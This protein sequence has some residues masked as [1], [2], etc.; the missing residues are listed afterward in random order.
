MRSGCGLAYSSSANLGPGFDSVAL[1]HDAY[2][3]VACVE[4]GGGGEGV[5]VTVTGPYSRHV[6]GPT[7]AELAVREAMKAMGLSGPVRVTL[8]K[9]VPVSAGLGGSAASAVAA[10]RALESALGISMPLELVVRLAGESEVASAG[11]PH[12]DNAAAS[13]AG[14]LVVVT[15]DEGVP[16]VVSFDVGLRAALLR[17][18][19]E[20]VQNKTKLMR[21]VLP[22]SVSM[23]QH[24]EDSSR[25]LVLL[26]AILRG[27]LRLAGR[28]MADSIV[29]PRR[30][31]LVPCFHRVRDSLL[32]AGAYGVAISGAGPSLIALGPYEELKDIASAGVSAYRSCGF[33]AEG[34]VVSASRGS[35]RIDEGEAWKLIGSAREA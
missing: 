15:V 23:R 24:V 25:A 21:E 8:W 2:Y 22:G 9:G 10:L 18:L 30:A 7:T 12:F 4:L 13:A 3:D 20:P 35:S 14:G 28:M 11:S 33:D 31:P 26:S 19:V 27:D 5:S 34:L 32:E 29:T 6:R 17:P 16:R 1:S